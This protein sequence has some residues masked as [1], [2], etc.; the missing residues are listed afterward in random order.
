MFKCEVFRF[1]KAGG[2]AIPSLGG[3]RDNVIKL[4]ENTNVILPKSLVAPLNLLRWL[5]ERL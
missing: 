5:A 1:F 4:R 2:C 3:R